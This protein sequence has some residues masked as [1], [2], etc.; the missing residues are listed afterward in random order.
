[1]I[2]WLFDVHAYLHAS[3]GERVDFS[4]LELVRPVADDFPIEGERGHALAEALLDCACVH[5][6]VTDWDGQLSTLD[7]Q[8]M[9]DAAAVFSVEEGERHIRYDETLLEEPAMLVAALAHELS[10]HLLHDVVQEPPG[11]HRLHEHATDALS[12]FLGFGIFAANGAY[13]R[14]ALWSSQGWGYR[15][16]RLGYLGQETA[17]YALALFCALHAVDPGR[18]QGHLTDQPLRVFRQALR[19]LGGERREDV[20]WLRAKIAGEPMGERPGSSAQPPPPSMWQRLSQRFR[21]APPPTVAELAE[22]L[23]AGLKLAGEQRELRFDPYSERL[24]LDGEPGD[25]VIELE[26]LHADYVEMSE[27]ERREAVEFWAA[28]V[29]IV[30]ERLEDAAPDLVHSLIPTILV[31]LHDGPARV[32]GDSDVAIAKNEGI[33]S[34]EGFNVAAMLALDAPFGGQGARDS[35]LGT[36]ECG[37]FWVVPVQRDLL[38]VCD[39]GEDATLML[40]VAMGMA[41]EEGSWLSLTPLEVPLEGPARA[42]DRASARGHLAEQLDDLQRCERHSHYGISEPQAQAAH[43]RDV[44]APHELEVGEHGCRTH[45]T[46]VYTCPALLPEV[47]AVTLAIEEDGVL[48]ERGEVEWTRLLEVMAP[49]RAD[50]LPPPRFRMVRAPSEAELT[51]MGIG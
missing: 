24:L 21:G 34:M 48:R 31:D 13:V 10:H 43:P 19:Q 51:G 2:D 27:E 26:P 47:D 8:L 22:R 35:P 32:D 45:T 7:R 39:A 17:S 9:P 12:I 1:M 16:G 6:G 23:A 38:L 15:E 28:P 5:M 3:L 11:G 36:P 33:V 41:I 29:G 49:T 42:I 46:W 37:A 25:D 40:V 18:A 20:E 50:G 30:P 4:A 44:I 14:R